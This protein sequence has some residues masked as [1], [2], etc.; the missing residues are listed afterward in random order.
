FNAANLPEGQL[1]Q[2]YTLDDNFFHAAY[3]GSFLNHQFLIAAAPPPWNQAI[4]AGF[5]SRYD[6]V[7]H[8]LADSKLTIDRQYDINTTFGA[9]TPHPAGIPAGQLLNVINDN[10]PFL[11]GGV[12]DPSY[13]PTIGDRLDTAPG[14]PISWKWYSGGWNQALAGQSDPAFTNLFQYH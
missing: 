1:A 4:P 3:G 2:Q 12:P 7:N 11:P 6:P 9:Q 14:G 8:T 13:T 5:Q 10:H